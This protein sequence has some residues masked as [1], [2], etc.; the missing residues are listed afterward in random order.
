MPA[1]KPKK[2]KAPTA[3]GH[4]RSDAEPREVLDPAE[5]YYKQAREDLIAYNRTTS[6]DPAAAEYLAEASQEAFGAFG[7]PRSREGFDPRTFRDHK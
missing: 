3:R 2:P 4:A 1:R 6:N 5:K 7:N